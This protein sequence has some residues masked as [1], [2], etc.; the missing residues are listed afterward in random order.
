[1]KSFQGRAL[2]PSKKL[3]KSSASYSP[4]TKKTLSAR[5][6][7]I[8]TRATSSGQDSSSDSS[9]TTPSVTLILERSYPMPSRSS[10]VGLSKPKRV[11]ITIFMRRLY[12]K[13]QKGSSQK[14]LKYLVK[15]FFEFFIV[16]VR[17]TLE[18]EHM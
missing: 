9:V 8:F 12:N 5:L 10:L 16:L 6:T 1:M 17:W 11:V 14:V 18:N 3:S 7:F 15:Y 2:Q 4:T 13:Y